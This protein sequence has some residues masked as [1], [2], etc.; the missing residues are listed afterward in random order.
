LTGLS[1][2]ILFY[3]RLNM[4]VRRAK[5]SHKWVGVLMLD[6]DHFKDINDQ[7]GHAAGDTLLKD[8][9]ER[10]LTIVRDTDT[11]AR[12][13]G[14]EFWIALPSLSSH[15]DLTQIA[16]KI[17]D[18]FRKPFHLDAFGAVVTISVGAALYPEN[19][20]DFNTLMEKADKAMYR[21]K[22]LGRNRY[23]FYEESTPT[24]KKGK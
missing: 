18:A 19:G 3:D 4:A 22:H 7:W 10:L 17:V 16:E 11:V 20:E 21:A 8:V 24:R 14:D 23:C 2:R 1:N 6:L 5:R 13:G 9:A 12:P 15:Q